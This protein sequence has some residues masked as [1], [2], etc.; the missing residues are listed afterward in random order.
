MSK[1]TLTHY[2]SDYPK[3]TQVHGKWQVPYNIHSSVDEDGITT[4]TAEV[5]ECKTLFEHDIR[6]AIPSGHDAAVLEAIKH[7]IRLQREQEYPPMTDYLD[8]VA[9]D[10]VDQIV[11]YKAACLAVKAKY[12]FPDA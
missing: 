1:T 2:G 8:G 9:K 7:G 6:Q 12:P 3:P 4:Y 11:S 5:A 10:D